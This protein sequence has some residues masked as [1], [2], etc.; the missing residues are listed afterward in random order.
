M[1]D[2]C[3]STPLVPSLNA[4]GQNDGQHE[5]DGVHGM[6]QSAEAT[7]RGAARL[8]HCTCAKFQPKLR[9]S[10]TVTAAL[11]A[12]DLGGSA[13]VHAEKLMNR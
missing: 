1:T 8:N 3:Q 4:V 9:P 11:R 2:R 13:T 5:E 10:K 6:R 7:P 12:S